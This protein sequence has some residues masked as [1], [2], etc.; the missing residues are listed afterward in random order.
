MDLTVNQK[1]FADLYI[2]TG[3]AT[4]S[5]AKVYKAKAKVCEASSC[6]LLRNG[7]IIT[8]LTERNKKID[9]TT[10]ADMVEVKEFWSSIFR[11]GM[12]TL[13]VDGNPVQRPVDIKDRIK[14]SEFIAKT[15]GAFIEKIDIEI[16][17]MPTIQIIK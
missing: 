3:N 13:I 4:E 2:K 9:R 14:A 8:Y 1:K 11:T 16:T 17:K 10:I 12:E 15:N 7:K 5:Y 6:R